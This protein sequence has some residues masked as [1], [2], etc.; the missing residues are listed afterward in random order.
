MRVISEAAAFNGNIPPD[1][2]WCCAGSSY[3]T[4]FIDTPVEQ[5]RS[6]IDS[7]YLSSAYMAHAILN[8]WLNPP[9]K[10][11]AK[12]IKAG[13]RHLIFTASILSFFTITGY[14][15]YSPT[16]AALR[17]LSDTLSQEM[18]LYASSHTPVRIHTIFP[19]T[20]FTES[21]ENENKVK[22]DVTKKLEESDPGQTP[23]EVAKR[24]IAGLEHGEELVTTTLLTRLVK[25]SVLGGSIR[26]GWAILDTVLSWVMA[27]VMVFV[28]SDMDSK[29]RKWG[30]EHGP[31]GMEK[32]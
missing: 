28:R 25:A 30:K 14:A 22:A 17:S 21:Y 13:P 27:L 20:I 32:K 10:S 3:P 24:S 18:N 16:K 6:Q 7:N 29:V 9:S 15:P 8:A 26:N 31:S 12:D 23:E 2:V 11:P 19:A 1:I 5:L 4:L